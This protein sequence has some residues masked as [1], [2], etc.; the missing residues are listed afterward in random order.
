MP[1]GFDDEKIDA[2][3]L[4]I[5]ALKE[6]EKTLDETSEC[7]KETS[8][9]MKRM[10]DGLF[11][12]K[13]KV[14]RKEERE[15]ATQP[16]KMGPIIVCDEWSA[17]KDTCLNGRRITFQ[18]EKN[19]FQ[20]YV[21]INGDIFRYSEDLPNKIK[22]FEDQHY[23]SI[24]KNCFRSIDSLRFLI[25]RRL[26]CG[27]NLSIKSSEIVPIEKEFLLELVYSFD[28][29]EVKEFLSSELGVPTDKICVG[30]ITY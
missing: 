8:K 30:K 9:S 4:V 21:I 7:L 14:E 29:K 24:D 20:V 19:S 15:I 1:S 16:T 25:D 11:Y 6:H 3:D 27:I 17:F 13:N 12:E 26:E 22:I 18:I 23:F 10:V 28:V 5:T 2:L